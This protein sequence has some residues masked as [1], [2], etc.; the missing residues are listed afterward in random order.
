MARLDPG[1]FH[2]TV[3]GEGPLL[4]EMM[5][6]MRRR[7]LSHVTFLG[8]IAE[9]A[10]LAEIY[11]GADVFV[12]PNPREPF[13]IAPLEAM[14]AGLALVAPST[15]GVTSYANETNSWLVSPDAE[16]VA[17]AVRAIRAN[18]ADRAARVGAARQTALQH[19]WPVVTSRF[20]RLYE[21]LTAITKD[22]RLQAKATP[23][24]WSTET[25]FTPNV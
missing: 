19:D 8:H 9:R 12:H 10:A 20:L 17:N 13:G 25:R 22:A 15:G 18:P 23:R 14:A 4:V 1:K 6:E 11:A 5:S 16:S 3:A 2:L 21:E 24:S 7:E